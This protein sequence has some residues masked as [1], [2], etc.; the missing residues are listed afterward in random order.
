M[1]TH[2]F[3]LFHEWSQFIKIV[4]RPSINLKSIFWLCLLPCLAI[5][6]P[7]LTEFMF[8]FFGLKMKKKD[9]DM[10]D[11]TVSD[12]T[13]GTPEAFQ[14]PISDWM[15]ANWYKAQGTVTNQHW[16]GHTHH[17]NPNQTTNQTTVL[18]TGKCLSQAYHNHW[19]LCTN[20][21]C[22][23]IEN[24]NVEPCVGLSVVLNTELLNFGST[25]V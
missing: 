1:R 21:I 2:R 17:P 23:H 25:S 13:V 24:R 14:H 7:L 20:V 19:H 4:Y 6:C 5:S 10:L 22:T 15:L 3:Q 18:S 9:R 8:S 12:K 11:N 16:L